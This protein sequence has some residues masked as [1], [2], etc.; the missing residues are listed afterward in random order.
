MRTAG[1]AAPRQHQVS[2]GLI[3]LRKPLCLRIGVRGTLATCTRVHLLQSLLGLTAY[4]TA[5]FLERCSKGWNRR[6][7]IGTQR[8]ESLGGR[9]ADRVDLVTEC[10]DK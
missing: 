2:G 4:S 10:F 6:L 1:T 5:F 9:R 7:G 3:P 8:P